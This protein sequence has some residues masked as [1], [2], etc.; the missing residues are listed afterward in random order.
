MTEPGADSSA[1]PARIGPYRLAR[2]LGEGGMGEVFLAW[3]DRLGRRVAVKRIRTGKPTDTDRERLRREAR[4]AARLSHPYVVQIYDLVEDEAGDA[5]VLEYV[6]GRTLRDILAEGPP[7]PALALRL[8]REMTE[9]IAAAHAAGLVHR[10]L[11]AENVVV[12]REGHAKILDF[13]IA[14][15]LIG[16]FGGETLTLQGAVLGTAHSMSPEQARGGEV[17]TRSDLFSLGVLLYELLTGRSPFRGTNPLDTMHR[18]IS[19]QPPPVAEVRPGISRDLSAL[20]DRLLAKRPEDRPHSAAEVATL[21][22]A[23]PEPGPEA[24]ARPTGGDT[25]LD[26]LPPRRLSPV[27]TLPVGQSA[28]MTGAVT[29]GRKLPLLGL[30]ALLLAVIATAGYLLKKSEPPELLRIAVTAPHVPKGGE[31]QFSLLSS[32]VLT[33]ALSTL[34]SMEGLAPLDPTQAG[35]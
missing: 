14:K 26:V 1:E 31:D 4:A 11:K 18:V 17:D 32:S 9:G 13:G 10:D 25:T 27:L 12:T 28:G 19:H 23:F 29:R 33:A 30:A 6:E 3:D 34:A 22:S 7:A 15:A 2:R 35:G 16:D 24:W 8:A 21:L 20:V 5:I